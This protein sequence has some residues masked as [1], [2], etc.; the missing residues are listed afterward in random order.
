[1]P[2]AELEHAAAHP[3]AAP[4]RPVVGTLAPIMAVVLVAYLVIGVAMP[5][6]PLYVHQ[7]L[8]LGT[9]LVGLAAGVQF[10][11]AL[12][13]RFWSG[14]YADTRGAK[15]AVVAG[16]LLGAGA[17]LLYLASLRVAHA[18]AAALAVLL[19]GRVLLGGAESFVITGALSWGL[20]LGGGRNTGK[21]ISWV[22]TALWAAYAAGAPAGTALYGRFGFTGIAL[23]TLLLPL[24]TLLLVAP[25]RAPAPS[26]HASPPFMQVVGA[27]WVPG[28]GAA[29]TAVGFGALTTF[30]ALLFA[31]R[32]WGA[33]WLAFTALSV[34]FILGRV[35]FGHLPD[36]LGGARVA[37]VCVL[38]ETAGMA[39]IWLAPSAAV[40]FVGAAVAGAGYS[41][42]YPG[43][44]IEA[45]RRAAPET[46]GLAMGAYTAFLDLSLG[47]ASP[48]LG[49][50]AT[51]AGLRAVFFVSTLV[52]LGGAAVAVR[53]LPPPA[54]A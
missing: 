19:L 42:V 51:R 35:L 47:V 36:R 50:V 23:A 21:V 25:L 27:V 17:G 26:A 12:V 49:L 43:F 18:P 16:L 40:V 6:L 32:G 46:R 24:A 1:M 5:V 39:T 28:M 45:V 3:G 4:A 14:R 34:S 7:E 44:G 37:L 29:L 10:A 2:H 52:V 20:A 11:A 48:A 9:F 31:D 13:S 38:V 15:R 33:A 8:G 53:L 54:R 22:G 41:L 30:G